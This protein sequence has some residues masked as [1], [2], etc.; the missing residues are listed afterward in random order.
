MSDAESLH[1]QTFE[2]LRRSYAEAGYNLVDGSFEKGGVLNSQADVLLYEQGGKA[3]SW[4]GAYPTGGYVVAAGTDPKSITEFSSVSN[5]LRSDIGS[6][7]GM[8]IVGFSYDSLA[9][10]SAVISTFGVVASAAPFL[11]NKNDAD[12]TDKINSAIAFA[13]QNGLPV[14]FDA[15]YQCASTIQLLDGVDSYATSKA[16]GV[17]FTGQ[18]AAIKCYGNNRIVGM[19]VKGSNSPTSTTI[20]QDGIMPTDDAKNIHIDHCVIKGFFAKGFPIDPPGMGRGV[21]LG[22]SIS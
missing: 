7:G 14:I 17:D 15:L 3:Y 1:A 5:H 22:A 4:A 13:K 10:A 11:A 16:F 21:T 8:S 9:N 12:N 6:A 20:R 18:G 2:A 19:L